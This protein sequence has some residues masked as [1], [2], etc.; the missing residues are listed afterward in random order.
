MWC[1]SWI[2]ANNVLATSP[3]VVDR[4]YDNVPIDFINKE[5][6]YKMMLSAIQ[7]AIAVELEEQLEEGSLNSNFCPELWDFLTGLDFEGEDVSLE[8]YNL[9]CELID[10]IVLTGKGTNLEDE[11]FIELLSRSQ[12]F[13]KNCILLAEKNKN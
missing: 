12:E 6:F 2:Y 1:I 3:D 8:K 9:F 4:S 11:I 10:I 13:I 5:E 7:S